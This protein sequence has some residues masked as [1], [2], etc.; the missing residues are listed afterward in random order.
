M[1]LEGPGLSVLIVDDEDTIRDVLRLNLVRAGY[2]VDEAEN[3]EEA[4]LKVQERKPDIMILDLM[5]PG[6]S[7]FD[8]CEHLRAEEDTADLPIIILSARRDTMAK[9]EGKRVGA[10]KY[11]SKPLAPELLI[12][13]IEDVMKKKLA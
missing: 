2:L 9:Q 13:H 10:N 5:M 4:L 1:S 12:W 11:L 8:V 6:M 7:G 3:G